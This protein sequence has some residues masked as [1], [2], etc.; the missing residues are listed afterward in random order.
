MAGDSTALQSATANECG[1]RGGVAV[2]TQLVGVAHGEGALAS[3]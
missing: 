2:D 3:L 1:E